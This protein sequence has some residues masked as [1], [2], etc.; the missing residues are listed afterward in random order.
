MA[1]SGLLDGL[2]EPTRSERAEL[3]AWLLDRGI[4]VEQIRHEIAPMLLAPRRLAGDDADYVSARE[5][6]EKAGID[7][8]LLQRM[9]R[10]MGLS[11]VDD[12]D[13]E[14][15][16][17]ADAEAVL[18]AERF[19][20]MGI[21]ADQVVQITRMLSEG[22]GR[23]AEVMRY[24]ALATVMAP[25]ATELEIAKGSEELVAEVVPL[26]GPMISALL[27]VQLRHVM[28]EE[29]VN[30]SERAKGLPLPGARVVTVGFAD[31]VG[32]TKLGEMMPPEE[33]ER[34]ANRLAEAA[35]EV[36]VG[37]V[38]LIKTIGDAVM[39]VSPDPAELLEAM[40]ALVAVTETDPDFPRLR[41]G[42][43]TGS[44]VNRAGDWFGSPVNL[45]SRVTGAARPGTVLVAESSKDAVGENDR[46][47]WSYAG[48]R[49]LKGIKGEV[50]LFRVRKQGA[51][52][53]LYRNFTEPPGAR[54]GS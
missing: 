24:A 16:L 35:R 23:A 19:I 9:Q 38:R 54:P 33:L 7:L 5:I 14:V 41:V 30:A 2:D 45:A 49:H 29:A 44:A 28:A 4:T 53:R 32:F 51:G 52:T 8:D 43:A 3:I 6:S 25:G 40:L 31:L 13:A 37:S 12:P 10:A 21:D 18:F 27:F 39:L 20:D 48:S 46:F 1:A 42:A 17:R 22:L 15:H 50:K 36:A 26:L 47:A 11:T 34:L